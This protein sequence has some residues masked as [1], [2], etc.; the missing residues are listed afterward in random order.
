MKNQIP[1]HRIQ[2]TPQYGVPDVV[3]KTAK[4]GNYSEENITKPRRKPYTEDPTLDARQKKGN[5]LSRWWQRHKQW[6]LQSFVKAGATYIFLGLLLAAAATYFKSNQFDKRSKDWQVKELKRTPVDSN[7]NKSDFY[8]GILTV[9]AQNKQDTTQKQIDY[10]ATVSPDAEHRIG[11][12]MEKYFQY[13]QVQGKN[14][15]LD[16]RPL[17]K[18]NDPSTNP[19]IWKKAWGEYTYSREFIT[20]GDGFSI[21]DSTKRPEMIDNAV[22]VFPL[23][24]AQAKEY[25]RT[26]TVKGLENRGF[27][28][29]DYRF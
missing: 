11:H 26:G 24:E 6:W 4:P 13:F 22:T 28:K 9:V 15:A 2:K 7:L 18:A 20:K 29:R 3:P 1:D 27:K 16:L 21:T 14:M 12:R 17:D 19:D 5:L 8:D 10:Y 25:Q 23:S